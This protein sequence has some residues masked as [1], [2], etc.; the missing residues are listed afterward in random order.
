[1]TAA[2]QLD[3]SIMT[4]GKYSLGRG[5][6][7]TANWVAEHDPGY[8]VWAY[9]SWTPKPCS[10]L[11]YRECKREVEEDRRQSRVARDQDGQ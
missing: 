10:D 4:R 6:P 2:E 7:Q 1:M 3:H 8:L 9:E 11:L 5:N